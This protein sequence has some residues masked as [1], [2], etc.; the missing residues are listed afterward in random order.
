[1]FFRGEK[2]RGR[3]SEENFRRRKVGSLGDVNEKKESRGDY[4]RTREAQI[5]RPR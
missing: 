1:M 3:K 4:R 2:K 5:K